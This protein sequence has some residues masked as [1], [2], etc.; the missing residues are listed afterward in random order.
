[1]SH[2]YLRRK[3]H[4]VY[5]LMS[6]PKVVANSIVL[7]SLWT[8]AHTIGIVQRHHNNKFGLGCRFSLCTLRELGQITFFRSSTSTH[9]AMVRYGT[10]HA[11]QWSVPTP[12]GYSTWPLVVV[13]N[14]HSPREIGVGSVGPY[15]VYTCIRREGMKFLSVPSSP[16]PVRFN[17]RHLTLCHA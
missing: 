7:Q 12:Y 6:L 5:N 10:A 14:N 13:A 9:L 16:V 1:M 15:R 17:S 4:L 11:A 8:E 2:R 3:S